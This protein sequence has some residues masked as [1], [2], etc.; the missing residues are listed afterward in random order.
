MNNSDRLLQIRRACLIGVSVVSGMIGGINPLQAQGKIAIE[1]IVVDSTVL[2]GRLENGLTYYIKNNKDHSGSVCYSLIIKAGSLDE[3]DSQKGLAHFNEHLS[4]DGTPAFPNGLLD[5]SFIQGIDKKKYFA[6]ALTTQSETIYSLMLPDTRESL[7]DTALILFKEWLYCDFDN[8]ENIKKQSDIIAKE[9]LGFQDVSERG[10]RI[11]Y[12]VFYNNSKWAY[13]PSI[14]DLDV[15]R[16]ADRKEIVRFRNEWYRSDLSAVVV[17]GDVD[18]N[19]TLRKISELFSVTPNHKVQ[20]EKQ[21]FSVPDNEKRKSV[22]VSDKDQEFSFLSFYN[23]VKTPDLATKDGV[24]RSL[25]YS[26]MNRMLIGRLTDAREE[27]N[28]IVSYMGANTYFLMKPDWVFAPN[29][30]VVNGKMREAVAVVVREQERIARHGFSETEYKP[31]KEALMKGYSSINPSAGPEDNKVWGKSLEDHFLLN[32]P[33]SK[34]ADR[35]SVFASVL[36]DITLADINAMHAELWDER[37]SCLVMAVPEKDYATAPDENEVNNIVREVKSENL[38]AYRPCD[39]TLPLFENASFGEGGA[40]KK[41]IKLSDL[42]V[43]KYVLSNGAEVVFYEDTTKHGPIQFEAVSKGGKSLLKKELRSVADLACE[44]MNEGPV[45]R[46]SLNQF[47]RYLEHSSMS[48]NLAISD[49]TESVRGSVSPEAFESLM[50]R[51]NYL[52]QGNGFSDTRYQSLLKGKKDR[53]LSLMTST[54]NLFDSFISS[55]LRGE[56]LSGIQTEDV[57]LSLLDGIIKERFASKSDFTFYFTG[58]IGDVDFENLIARYLGEGKKMKREKPKSELATQITGDQ[59][60]DFKMGSDLR[61]QMKCVV[62][63]PYAINMD[64]ITLLQAINPII[65]QRLFAHVREELRLVYDIQSELKLKS[66][67]FARADFEVSFQCEPGDTERISKAIRYVFKEFVEKGPSSGELENVR[68]SM[69][70]AK[71]YYMNDDGF[72]LGCIRSHDQNLKNDYAKQIN[73]ISFIEKMTAENLQEMLK[74]LMDHKKALN[75]S[76][77]LNPAI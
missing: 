7:V 31:V 35:S 67:P 55:K 44:L 8:E 42:P 12:P 18:E 13:R 1:G 74:S 41:K 27:N 61:A 75:A 45:G 68:K 2:H 77:V 32:I 46:Y 72:R 66:S 70:Q 69:L 50:Q 60:F 64:N 26:M 22:V 20:R 25:I 47:Q 29:A 76:F 15:I 4:F 3:D 52:F 43:Y 57:T 48:M 14:G 63:A 56:E 36:K 17:V 54:D 38:E 40:I 6:N 19:E 59:Q 33:Y 23:R 5:G 30:S 37:N 39:T 10:R 53:Y 9:W 21:D 71:N 49:E 24:K 11:W 28:G 73:N 51:I 34:G 65:N 16:K 58:G 62:G